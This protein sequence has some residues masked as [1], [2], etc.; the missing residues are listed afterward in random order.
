MT[1]SSVIAKTANV[2]L[3]AVAALPFIAIAT[4]RAEPVTVKVSDLNMSRPA[5]VQEYNRRVDRA[6]DELC[7]QTTDTLQ[8]SRSASCAAAVR[9]EAAEKMSQRQAAA[10]SM[11]V[12]SR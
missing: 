5:H 3:F 7:A 11:S 6:A 12:A 1:M 8:L 10:N 4:A 2:A 9:Q